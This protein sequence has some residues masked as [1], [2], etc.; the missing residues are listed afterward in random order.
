MI[1]VGGNASSTTIPLV[2]PSCDASTASLTP[3][4]SPWAP[5]AATSVGAARPMKTS[6]PFAGEISRRIVG[7]DAVDPEA[8]RGAWG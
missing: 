2:T 6:S 5:G 4:A 3:C 8:K 7:W 1:S